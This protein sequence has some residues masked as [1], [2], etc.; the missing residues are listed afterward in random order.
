MGVE[1]RSTAVLRIKYP[2][3]DAFIVIINL[4]ASV[5][6]GVDNLLLPVVL[7]QVLEVF[8]ISWGRIWNIVIRQPSF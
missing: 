8:S 7:D 5:G 1:G 3:L 6:Y 4:L 2:G